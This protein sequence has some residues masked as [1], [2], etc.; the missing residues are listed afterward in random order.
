MHPLPRW[1]ESQ[2][3]SQRRLDFRLLRQYVPHTMQSFTASE[4]RDVHAGH[5]HWLTIFLRRTECTGGIR[6]R[7]GVGENNVVTMTEVA[8]TSTKVLDSNYTSQ[9]MI[10]VREHVSAYGTATWTVE[11]E[12]MR[13]SADERVRIAAS[14]PRCLLS[15]SISDNV[16]CELAMWVATFHFPTRARSARHKRL[17]GLMATGSGPRNKALTVYSQN[18]S[19]FAA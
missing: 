17:A 5:S 3:R 14:R 15:I 6:D 2:R 16:A 9:P 7:A 1:S 12:D 11:E 18:S 4:L 8:S 19:S 13:N 10:L